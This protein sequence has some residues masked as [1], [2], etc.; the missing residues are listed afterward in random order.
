VC[1]CLC[2]RVCVSV[3]V[4]VCVFVCACVSDSKYKLVFHRMEREE[5]PYMLLLIVEMSPVWRYCLKEVICFV[6]IFHI[7]ITHSAYRVCIGILTAC[8]RDGYFGNNNPAWNLVEIINL[9][10]ISYQEQKLQI[11][12]KIYYLWF[13]PYVL[14]LPSSEFFLLNL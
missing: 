9:V 8:I 11:I 1:V 5:L 10:P 4:C 7:K 13:N 2:V 6:Y 3:R 12:F 14:D